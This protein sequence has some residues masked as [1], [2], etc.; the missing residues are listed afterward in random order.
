ME[1][2]GAACL[3]PAPLGHRCGRHDNSYSDLKGT[4]IILQQGCSKVLG[5]FHLFK[6]FDVYGDVCAGRRPVSS[7]SFIESVV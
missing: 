3:P 4:G 7:C 6:L 1:A 2:E 5:A